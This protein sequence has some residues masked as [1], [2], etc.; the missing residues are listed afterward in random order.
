MLLTLPTQ[1]H[2]DIDQSTSNYREM[3]SLKG[4]ASDLVF[5]SQVE[6]VQQTQDL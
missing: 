3:S 5:G 1:V 4:K 6:V 2:I